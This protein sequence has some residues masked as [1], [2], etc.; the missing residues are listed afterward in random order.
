MNASPCHLNLN[1]TVLFIG[2]LP[3][4]NVNTTIPCVNGHDSIESCLGFSF[5]NA[6]MLKHNNNDASERIHGHD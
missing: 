1:F 5:F 4:L 2:T 6:F 3:L